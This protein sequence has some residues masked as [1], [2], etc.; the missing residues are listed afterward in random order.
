MPTMSDFPPIADYA[1]L[2]DCEDSCLIAPDGT[3]EW[4]CLPRPDSP[5][6]FG[7]LLDRSAGSFRF[8]PSNTVGPPPPPLCARHHG[9]RDDLAHP[10]RLAGRPGPHG[11]PAKVDDGPAARLPAGP[12]RFGR[13]PGSSCARPG[14]F[15]ARSRSTPTASRC[16]TTAPPPDTGRTTVTAMTPSPSGTGRRP[17]LSVEQPPAGHRRRPLLRAHQ[18]VRGRGVLHRPVVGRSGTDNDQ[19]AASGPR[20][21]GGL[22]ASTGWPPGRSPTTRGAPTSSGAP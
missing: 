14:A 22:L 11:H 15:P 2:S 3:V 16:S 10:H 4:L 18:P 6:V 13:R 21:D 8:G 17:E 12:R 20:L 9:G 7:A 1:F 5:S 19:E